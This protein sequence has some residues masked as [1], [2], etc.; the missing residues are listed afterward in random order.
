MLLA[1]EDQEERLG[2]PQIPP[3]ILER[4]EQATGAT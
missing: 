2:S 3:L 4:R 1:D